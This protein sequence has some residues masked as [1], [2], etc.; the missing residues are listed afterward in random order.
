MAVSLLAPSPPHPPGTA[1]FRSGRG[2]SSLWPPRGPVE[3]RTDNRSSDLSF[4]P[5]SSLWCLQGLNLTENQRAMEPVIQSLK[6]SLLGQKAGCKN[7]NKSDMPARQV[8]HTDFNPKGLLLIRLSG[9]T[10][11]CLLERGNELG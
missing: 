3:T 5:P 2:E 9:C 11:P 6:V 1:T 7:L 8:Q 4:L 10:V